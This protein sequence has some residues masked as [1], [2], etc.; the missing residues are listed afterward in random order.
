MECH[1][2]KPAQ[3][4]CHLC[5]NVGHRSNVCPTPNARVCRICGTP[6]PIE[7][8][9]C[10][11]SC[12][13]RG[14]AHHTEYRHFK[15]RLKPDRLRQA[16]NRTSLSRAEKPK[17]PT[18]KRRRWFSSERDA[19]T[20]SYCRSRSASHPRDRPQLRPPTPPP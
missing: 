12:A 19:S 16:R 9:N 11:I 14:G 18:Q 13:L 6:N 2:N 15:E 1:V 7:D 3:Q 4:I 8:H 17:Y 20:D 10:A 5:C